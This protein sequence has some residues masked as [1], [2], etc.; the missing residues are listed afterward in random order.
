[1]IMKVTISAYQ[2]RKKDQMKIQK[3]LD[4]FFWATNVIKEMRMI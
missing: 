1:M 2:E 4:N 3:K